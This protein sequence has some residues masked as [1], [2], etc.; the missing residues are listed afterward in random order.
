MIKHSKTEIITN[1]ESVPPVF[2]RQDE[3]CQVWTNIITNA[4]QAMG[5]SGTLSITVNFLQSDDV[6]RVIFK[7]NGPGMSE[8]VRSRIFEPYF[9][10][11]PKG[12]GTGIGLD[13]S[14]QIIESHKGKIY[15]ESEPGAGATFII[16]IPLNQEK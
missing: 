3:I 15:C 13:L 11:K 5:E 1:L 7:D 12:L 8:E 10:T 6:I 9:T 2:C 16:E 14:K 4:I